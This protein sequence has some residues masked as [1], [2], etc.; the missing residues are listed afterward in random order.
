MGKLIRDIKFLIFSIEKELFKSNTGTEHESF[1]MDRHRPVLDW[2]R[3]KQVRAGLD[4]LASVPTGA[5]K[6]LQS[7]YLKETLYLK[8]NHYCIF[9]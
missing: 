1:D 3:S 7:L 5:T 9:L 4:Q 2:Y 6:R 8:K